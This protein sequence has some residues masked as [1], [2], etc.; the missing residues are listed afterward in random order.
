M[1]VFQFSLLLFLPLGFFSC[2]PA[3]NGPSA[4]TSS[5]PTGN[6]V[7][8]LDTEEYD[9]D[10]GEIPANTRL[11]RSFEVCNHTVRTLHVRS[12]RTAGTST[13][14]SIEPTKLGPGDKAN[15]SVATLIPEGPGLATVELVTED[16]ML[17]PRFVLRG[18][19]VQPPVSPTTIDFGRVLCGESKTH[20]LKVLFRNSVVLIPKSDSDI[21]VH[22]LDRRVAVGGGFKLEPKVGVSVEGT[23]FVERLAGW[24][25]PV[26]IKCEKPEGAV[27]TMLEVV[28]VKMPQTVLKVP[29]RAE[30][31]GPVRVV[32]PTVSFF[33]MG[34]KTRRERR[35][36]VFCDANR[37]FEA[38]DCRSEDAR[39][40]VIIASRETS[41]IDIDVRLSSEYDGEDFESEITLATNQLEQPEVRI[42]VHVL[43]VP[44]PDGGE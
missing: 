5:Q 13:T 42:P 1:R 6:V 12:L 2:G 21:Q 18:I 24:S 9:H 10:S 27:D 16:G 23:S 15:L 39:I 32:P 26:T 19:G 22:S 30:L 28:L 11:E 43:R 29:V 37:H 44:L 17:A 38:K 7:A 20:D 40:S 14:A 35:V 25:F 4:R 3:T 33:L 41:K 31:V 34:D 8:T 36:Q